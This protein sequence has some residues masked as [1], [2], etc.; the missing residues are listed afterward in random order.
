[1]VFADCQSAEEQVQARPAAREK[2]S[3]KAAPCRRRSDRSKGPSGEDPRNRGDLQVRNPLGRLTGGLRGNGRYS[4]YLQRA[5]GRCY[6][7]FRGS[8]FLG[9]ACPARLA[10]PL[11]KAYVREWRSDGVLLTFGGAR[12]RESR[13]IHRDA[14]AP[15]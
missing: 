9:L 15:G 7:S 2:D 4:S 12:H 13:G 10:S 1:M 8:L 14:I 5:L 3:V 6:W 11:K